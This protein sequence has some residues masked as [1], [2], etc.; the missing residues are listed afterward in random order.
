[1]GVQGIINKI[2]TKTSL[3]ERVPSRRPQPSTMLQPRPEVAPYGERATSFVLVF[4]Q[5]LAC[6]AL[7]ITRALMPDL[8]PSVP[9][10]QP[11]PLVKRG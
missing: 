4:V 11:T 10:A 6:D 3:K 2:T 8:P 5:R 7:N 1:M 9:G